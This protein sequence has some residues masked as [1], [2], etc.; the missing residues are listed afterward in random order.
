MKRKVLIHLVSWAL[1]LAILAA[2]LWLLDL[3]T[4]A[5]RLA[6]TNLWAAAGAMLLVAV[7]FVIKGLRW[8][9]IARAE[10]NVRAATCIRLH[11]VAVFLNAFIPLRGGDVARGLVLARE[12]G[13]GRAQA[14][15]TVALDKLFDM[16]ALVVLVVP[17]AFLG[18]LPDWI[19]WPPVIT[20][21]V[22]AV[23]LVTGLVLRLRLRS[24]DE[25]IESARW[26]VRVL[27]GFAR[28]FDSV[29]R[30]GPVA[31]CAAISVVQYGILVA[32][33]ALALV[34]VGIEPDAGTSI[35]STLAV[36][37]AAG[38]PLTPSSAGTLHGAVTAALAAIG[39]DAESGMSAAVVYHAAQTIP[40]L[41]P[42]VVLARGTA[43]DAVDAAGRGPRDTEQ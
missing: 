36:Q 35:L 37:F 1:S 10:G 11:F 41:L 20:V 23:L 33:M 3:H 9:V 39:V 31:L 22:A 24:R 17:L 5:A 25:G 16:L 40:I 42:G 38:V 2:L 4:L 12:T 8:W 29:R 30:P 7:L 15:G 32:S 27:A 28:G 34:S 13:M 14:L 6:G 18:G 43:L 21:C 19:R 26:I